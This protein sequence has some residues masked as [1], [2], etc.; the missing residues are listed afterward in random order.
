MAKRNPNN[1]RIKRDYFGYLADAKGLSNV[2]I[3]QRAAAIQEFERSTSL[4]DFRLFRIEQA[5]CF[6][7]HLVDRVNPDTGKP[8]S[9][10]TVKSRLA[11]VKDFFE[12]LASQPGYRSKITFT[13]LAYFDLPAKERAIADARGEKRVPSLEQIR[14]VIAMMPAGT[15]IERRDRALVAFTILTG[16]R[17]DAIASLSLRHV[18]IDR[19]RIVQ[20][21]RT[22]VRTKFSKTF[23]TWFFPVGDDI[24]AIVIDWV[25]FLQ[26]EKLFGPDDP[27]FP[28]TDVGHDER[29]RF[30]TV[31]LAREHWA[32]AQPIRDIFRRAFTTAGLPYHNPH[33]FRATLALFGQKVCPDIEQMKAWSQNLGHSQMLTTLTSYGTVPD[34][35]QAEIFDE[36]QSL[37]QAAN[38]TTS[39]DLLSKLRAVLEEHDASSK[40]SSL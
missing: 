28:R 27:L 33:S 2:T 5:R 6:K 32:N 1:E 40:H 12:W 19:R 36:L 24:E 7:Q 29:Q 34:H 38:Q 11:A 18:E 35:R 22:G 39:D 26:E 14:H 30:T 13:D 23:A 9:R 17:D 10:S 20:D 4:R 31:G 8:L 21:P 15:E 37:G 3:D 25:R 16:A